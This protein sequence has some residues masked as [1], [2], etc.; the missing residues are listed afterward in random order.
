MKQRGR[1]VLGA[2]AGL[3]FGLFISLD[4][5]VFGVVPLESNVLAVIPLVGLI[6]GVALGLTAPLRRRKAKQVHTTPL[7]NFDP[8]PGAG[9]A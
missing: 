5:F 4:L 8:N 6:A 9:R 7:S 1:P 3:F 2:I